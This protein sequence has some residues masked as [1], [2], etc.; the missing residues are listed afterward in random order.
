MHDRPAT[1]PQIRLVD[2]PTRTTDHRAVT[3]WLARQLRWQ[4]RLAELGR[5]KALAT[6]DVHPGPLAHNRTTRVW[7]GL[8]AVVIGALIAG[9]ISVATPTTRTSPPVRLTPVAS[10]VRA[11]AQLSTCVWVYHGM[12][13]RAQPQ[14]LTR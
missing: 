10:P 7:H 12:F 9:A 3:G 4:G 2:E 6:S 13:C 1:T 11:A 5:G 14:A 8:V